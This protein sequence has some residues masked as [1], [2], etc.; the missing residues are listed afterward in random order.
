M[1]KDASIAARYAR[2]LRILTDK[3]AAKAGT[4]ALPALEAALADL[5]GLVELL[6][7]GTRVGKFLIDPQVSPADRRQ[8]LERGLTGKAT[9]GVRVFAD[10]LLRKKRLSMIRSVAHEFQVIVERIKGLERA[11]VVS[12]VPLEKGEVSRLHSELERVTGHK[13]VLDTQVDASLVGGAYVRI[14]DRV[15]DRS[16]KSLLASLADK[17]YEVSV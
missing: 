4:P 11:T 13:I 12:A 8:V 2:A 15:I 3:Q 7:P 5:Q 16:V 14:G 10:L 9:P 6:A 1:I 17:L